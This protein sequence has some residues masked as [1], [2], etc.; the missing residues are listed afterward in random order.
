MVQYST[1]FGAVSFIFFI[2]F[3]RACTVLTKGSANTLS[4]VTRFSPLCGFTLGLISTRF[5]AT[6]GRT[7]FVHKHLVE[8]LST[9]FLVSRLSFVNGVNLQIFCNVMNLLYSYTVKIEDVTR[10]NKNCSHFWTSTFIDRRENMLLFVGCKSYRFL[11]LVIQRSK[12][13]IGKRRT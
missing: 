3:L 13:Q 6:K 4:I 2:F 7:G 12:R 10:R 11:V 8:F 9:L 5:S 1:G